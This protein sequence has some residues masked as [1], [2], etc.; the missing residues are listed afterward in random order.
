M[1]PE[2][3]GTARGSCGFLDV[4]TILGKDRHPAPRLTGPPTRPSFTD[5][6]SCNTD[7]NFDK[8]PDGRQML[9]IYRRLRISAGFVANL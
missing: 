2:G 8:T 3:T 1:P 9:S 5:P 6:S 7:P 4:S